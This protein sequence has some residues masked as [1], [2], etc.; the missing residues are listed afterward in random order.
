VAA[1][2]SPIDSLGDPLG[3]RVAL[4]EVVGGVRKRAFSCFF[5]FGVFFSFVS[6]LGGNI[7]EGGGRRGGFKVGGVG[8][9]HAFVSLTV[10]QTVL[11]R[12]EMTNHVPHVSL[13]CAVSP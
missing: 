2:L 3:A 9:G 4:L 1:R 6:F 12:A 8:G 10:S 5:C 11:V 13:H 7:Q